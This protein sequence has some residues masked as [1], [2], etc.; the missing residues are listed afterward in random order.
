MQFDPVILNYGKSLLE[1]RIPIEV[2]PANPEKCMCPSV[3]DSQELAGFPV[4]NFR[5]IVPDRIRG[6]ENKLVYPRPIQN[7]EH[8]PRGVIKSFS[9]FSIFP[10]KISYMN[11]CVSH[12][13]ELLWV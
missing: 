3:C 2:I 10:W 7:P 4:H 13:H 6:R 11:M 12:N 9:A 1:A 8:L 5:M